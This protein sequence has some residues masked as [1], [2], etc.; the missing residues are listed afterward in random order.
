MLEIKNLSIIIET[1]YLIKDLSFV[2][3]MHDKLAIIGEEGNGKST[4]L[5]AIAG[6]CDYGYVSGSINLKGHRIGYLP[7]MIDISDLEKTVY[8]YL[9]LDDH[10]YYNKVNK[11]YKLLIELNLDEN[12][13]DS[14]MSFLSGGEK[15][16]IQILKLLLDEVDILILD[17]PTNDLDLKT[18]KWLENFVVKSNI[19]IIYVSHDETFLERTANV[20]LH[21]EQ[22]KKKD[23]PKWTLLKSN[24]FDYV[25]KRISSIA[26]QTQMAYSDKRKYKEKEEKL[27]QLINKVEYRQETI[28]RADAHGGRLLK[29]KMKDLKS[30]EKRLDNFDLT[31][32]PDVEEAIYFSFPSTNLPMRKEIVKLENYTLKIGEKTLSQNINLRI[33]GKDHIVIIG[34]NGVGKTTLIKYIYELLKVRDDLKVG[35]MPQ[36]YDTVLK[37]YKTPI[38]FLVSTGKK[39]DIEVARSYLGNMH[40]TKEEMTSELDLLSGGSKAKLFLLKLILDKNNVL[41]LDEPTRNVSPLSN[42][43]IRER[44][45][46][47]DGCIISISHDRKYIEEVANSVYYLRPDGLN[48]I[49][50]EKI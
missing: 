44:L 9:F 26:H 1:R 16:K 50:K 13:L 43:I 46:A 3:N 4:L 21:L 48:E 40:F 24:Y 14:H 37:K 39:E 22:L 25:N 15:V 7:Q 2:L 12:I 41:I 20:I 34:D 27:Q 32:V 17:E 31:E 47:F 18:L 19:P 38:D 6:L 23:E 11:L 5:K 42:P 8:N 10:D 28:T 29:K 35:Y 36:D 49:N 30:Q 33:I 45:Q